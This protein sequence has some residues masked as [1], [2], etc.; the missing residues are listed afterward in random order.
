MLDPM[1]NHYW[2]QQRERTSKDLLN[3][4]YIC[5]CIVGCHVWHTGLVNLWNWLV[6]LCDL[7]FFSAGKTLKGQS[8]KVQ[9]AVLQVILFSICGLR[10]SVS[11]VYLTCLCRNFG[12]VG[13][14][15][16][17]QLQLVKKV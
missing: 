17:L 16:L 14:M 13:T 3:L 2:A 7:L 6:I 5:T 11:V 10:S 1:N 12:Q 4:E 15:S 9:Q 8:Q